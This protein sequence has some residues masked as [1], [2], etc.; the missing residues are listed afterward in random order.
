MHPKDGPDLVSKWFKGEEIVFNFLNKPICKPTLILGETALNWCKPNNHGINGPKHS[1]RGYP[2]MING[3]V[4]VPSFS[5]REIFRPA[6]F[7]TGKWRKHVFFNDIKRFREMAYS[8]QP[9]ARNVEYSKS[10]SRVIDLINNIK[11]DKLLSVD[12]ETASSNKFITCIGIADTNYHAV[13]VPFFLAGVEPIWNSCEESEIISALK[14]VL[15]EARLVGQNCIMFDKEIIF[16]L[17][18]IEANFTDDLMILS[19]EIDKELPSNLEFLASFHTNTQYWKS[20]LSTSRKTAGHED[21]EFEYNGKDCCIT[22]EIYNKLMEVLK[23]RGDRAVEAYRTKCTVQ[24]EMNKHD[25]RFLKISN[26]LLK[27]RVKRLKDEIDKSDEEISEKYGVKFSVKSSKKVSNLLFGK[28]D[29]KL[30]KEVKTT[31]GIDCVEELQKEY[32]NDKDI[33]ELL[34]KIMSNKKKHSR[35]MRIIANQP[36]KT[37]FISIEN[38]VMR[39]NGPYPSESD[40]DFIKANPN[41]FIVTLEVV[42]YDELTFAAQLKHIGEDKMYDDLVKHLVTPKFYAFHILKGGSKS[43]N[44]MSAP[45]SYIFGPANPELFQQCKDFVFDLIRGYSGKRLWRRQFIKNDLFTEYF[46][47]EQTE[48]LYSD[49]MD[50]YGIRNYHKWIKSKMDE[51]GFMETGVGSSRTFRGPKDVATFREMIDYVPETHAESI[52][53]N[54]IKNLCDDKSIDI[55][56]MTKNK[57]Y[58]KVKKSDFENSKNAINGAI[59]KSSIINYLGLDLVYSVSAN[60]GENASCCFAKL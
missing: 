2:L 24:T 1:D 14:R 21:M 41:E 6:R 12:I 13:T 40:M 22:L 55:F 37:G 34:G 60:Y 54:I 51:N 16:N 4:C 59:C 36:S 58:M 27:H 33:S 49:L 38:N 47:I 53:E 28:L 17:W 26:A 31:A 43:D 50:L 15:T 45:K 42:D 44:P 25:K 29:L 3:N 48:K 19:S 5:P 52:V 9:I 10:F 18:G 23:G 11:T 8:W 39:K 32:I 35:V 56:S 7:Y 57:V 30:D 46:T 20:D